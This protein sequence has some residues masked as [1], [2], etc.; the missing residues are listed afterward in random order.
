METIIVFL[1]VGA[2]AAWIGINVCGKAVS[3]DGRCPG[4]CGCDC[5]KDPLADCRQEKTN[6]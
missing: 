1:I 3:E 2:A 4:G 6:P 5:G